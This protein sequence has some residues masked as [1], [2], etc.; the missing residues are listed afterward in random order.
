MDCT[1]RVIDPSHAWNWLIVLAWRTCISGGILFQVMMVWGKKEKRYTGTSARVYI[2]L[3]A[4]IPL[5]L[6][7]W[8][9]KCSMGPIQQKPDIPTRLC[10]TKSCKICFEQLSRPRTRSSYIYNLQ[11]KMGITPVH[12]RTVQLKSVL[13]TAKNRTEHYLHI[14]L[15]GKGKRH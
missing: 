4:A 5:V 1:G 13:F 8:I 10:T 2:V 9:C 3:K 7:S 15:H 11:L 6:L 12:F 14:G